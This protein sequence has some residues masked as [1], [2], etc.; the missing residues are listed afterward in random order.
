MSRRNRIFLGML[1]PSSNTTL[2]PV[3]ARML[4]GLPEVSAHAARFRVTEISLGE[5]ALGQFELEP[6]LQAAELL[7]DAHCHSICWN[8][9]SAGWLGLDADRKLCRAIEE[10]TGIPATSSVLALAEVFRMTAVRRY[11]LITPYTCDIQRAIDENFSREGFDCVAERHLDISVNFDF[12][13]VEPETLAGMVREVAQGGPQAITVFCTNMD[14]ASLAETLE[15]EI[16]IPVYDTI[17]LAVW[18]GLRAAG[19]DPSRVRGWGRLF[20]EVS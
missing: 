10:R 11:G 12:S 1:T 16:G 20:R 8:G 15:H 4:E 9:T 6:M 14:G 17:A 13:E 18:S 5:Q 3:M 2:E 7:A 19:V